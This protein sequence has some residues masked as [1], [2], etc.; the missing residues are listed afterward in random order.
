MTM[1]MGPRWRPA[2]AAGLA[3]LALLRPAAAL[4]LGLPRFEDL[5]PRFEAVTM[6]MT[7]EEVVRAMG[8]GPNGRTETQTM[9]VPH[10][11]LVWRDFSNQYV[12]RLLA[13]RLYFKQSTDTR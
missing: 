10:L 4:D 8:S 11:T 1:T 2:L 7:P 9:G 5:R 6:G 12:V 13:G 3:T